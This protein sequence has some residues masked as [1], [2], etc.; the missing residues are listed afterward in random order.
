MRF[1]KVAGRAAL[2]R[3]VAVERLERLS[4]LRQ[5]AEAE[6]ALAVRQERARARVLHDGGLAACKVGHR[7]VADPG[8]LERHA[9]RLCRT[10]LPARPSDVGGVGRG[11]ARDIPRV[12][13]APTL[14]FEQGPL[15]RV[16]LRLLRPRLTRGI[17]VQQVERQLEALARVAR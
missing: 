11:A 10:E 17:A 16:L 13:Y 8:I 14:P 3:V 1:G 5:R 9:R 15:L 6:H 4:R 2:A 7:P 12:P